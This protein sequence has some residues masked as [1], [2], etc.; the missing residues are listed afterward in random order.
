MDAH[1]RT[2]L[3]LSCL[4][5]SGWLHKMYAETFS[6]YSHNKVF[7]VKI[8]R[9]RTSHCYLSR[10]ISLS[11]SRLVCTVALFTLIWTWKYSR[12]FPVSCVVCLFLRETD[13][14]TN[15]QR[16]TPKRK[17]HFF[18]T[19]S[20]QMLFWLFGKRW[21]NFLEWIG[22]SKIEVKRQIGWAQILH[23]VFNF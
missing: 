11:L 9:F 8:H 10:S 20:K 18:F 4:Y 14:K 12:M 1:T 17:Q 5:S 23:F 15:N 19:K 3:F 2:R 6:I 7:M 22:R 16:K 21:L 13:M